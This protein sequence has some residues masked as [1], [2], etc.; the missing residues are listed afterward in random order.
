MKK[1][2]LWL[3]AA[4]CLLLSAC[5]RQPQKPE[6]PEQPDPPAQVQT[7]PETPPAPEEGAILLDRLTVELVVDWEDS[8]QVLSR[9]EE[10]SLLFSQ[11]LADQG[12]QVE[13]VTVTIS[14]A[15]G[16]TA[17]SLAEGGVDVAF[18]PAEDYIGVESE[19]G[20]VLTAGEEPCTTVAAVTGARTELDKAFCNTLERA[21]LET[22]DGNSFLE[23]CRPGAVWVP[24]TQETIAGVRDWLEEQEAQQGNS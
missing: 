18:L 21:M 4:L 22:E 17:G 12:C 5:G 6:Q 10:L 24:A 16:F 1:K 19:A 9:L 8:D 23:A 20:A 13:D 2:H 14:T 3:M 11:A 15:G 7:Q